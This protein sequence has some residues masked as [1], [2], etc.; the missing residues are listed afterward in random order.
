MTTIAYRKGVMA[1]DS[2]ASWD[3]GIKTCTMKKL[4]R[5]RGHLIGIAGAVHTA[6]I[7]LR[8]F[9]NGATGDLDLKG[10]DAEEDF[11]AMVVT[12]AQEIYTMTRLLTPVLEQAE[13]F[14]IGSGAA[15]AMAA[16]KMGGSAKRAVEVACEIDLFTGGP[17]KTI[18]FARGKN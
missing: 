13:F 1:A 3:S 16:M 18:R 17:V 6:G 2:Q 7:F 11:I 5:L 10:L 4:S 8:W 14:A 12:P 9:E 15:P